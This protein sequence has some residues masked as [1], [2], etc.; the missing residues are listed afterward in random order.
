[1]GI[2]GSTIAVKESN[3]EERSPMVTRYADMPD[4]DVVVVLGGS[5]DWFYAWTPVGEFTDR[6][7][8]RCV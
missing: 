1:M 2:N 8:Y 7:N 5:N 6:T 4:A 3:P